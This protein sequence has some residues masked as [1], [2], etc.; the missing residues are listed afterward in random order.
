[1][2]S[3]EHMT[4]LVGVTCVRTQ[5][6]IHGQVLSWFQCW[7]AVSGFLSVLRELWAKPEP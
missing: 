3:S 6:Y 1:M 5:F 7:Q 2:T 4:G